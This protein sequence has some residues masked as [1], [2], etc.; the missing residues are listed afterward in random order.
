[1]PR[2]RLTVNHGFIQTDDDIR[3]GVRALRR[4]CPVLRRIH[5]T[6]GDPPLRR[7]PAGLEGLCRIVVA[8]QLSTASAT[9]IWNRLSTIVDPFDAET[10]L[11]AS[12][13]A[14]RSAGLSRPKVK[15]LRAVAEAVVSGNL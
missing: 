5:D 10:L 8:Q 4:K 7:R 6:T 9:A 1:M 13:E 14:F 12:D 15:T 3:A 11:A 2:V